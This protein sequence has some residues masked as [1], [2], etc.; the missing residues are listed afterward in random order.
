M[1]KLK[2]V[3]SSSNKLNQERQVQERPANKSMIIC[4]PNFVHS[5]DSELCACSLPL[6]KRLFNESDCININAY[7]SVFNHSNNV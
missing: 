6:L 5:L 7:T 4:A 2:K 3:P 1:S